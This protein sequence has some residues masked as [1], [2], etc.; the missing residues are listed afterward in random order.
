MT[1]EKRRESCVFTPR[2]LQQQADGAWAK[3]AEKAARAVSDSGEG[4]WT[5]FAAVD[6]AVPAPV[7]TASLYV[8]FES[9]GLGELTSKILSATHSEFG[10][11]AER[12]R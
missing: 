12:Q 5:V 8:R 1:E 10:G 2:E 4:R 11:H 9:R 7:I 3:E 6:K